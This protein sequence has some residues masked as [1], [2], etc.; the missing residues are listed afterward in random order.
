MG[1]CHFPVRGFFQGV[2]GLVL[3]VGSLLC[4]V[5]DEDSGSSGIVVVGVALGSE[6]DVLEAISMLGC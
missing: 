1:G 3:W 4:V 6:E 2:K 5:F